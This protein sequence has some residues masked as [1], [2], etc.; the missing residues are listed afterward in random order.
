MPGPRSPARQVIES[1]AVSRFDR[2][3]ELQQELTKFP[4]SGDEQIALFI[5]HVRGIQAARAEALAHFAFPEGPGLEVMKLAGTRRYVVRL[6]EIAKIGRTAMAAGNI[7]APPE[8]P[9]N[10][11]DEMEAG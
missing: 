7:P 10:W 1:L 11:D 2:L 6:R 3:V 4:A 5:E 8:Q 9:L